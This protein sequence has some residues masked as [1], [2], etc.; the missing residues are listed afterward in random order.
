MLTAMDTE[1]SKQGPENGFCLVPG[2]RTWMDNGRKC[3]APFVRISEVI[4]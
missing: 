4:S 3:R 1:V 2:D